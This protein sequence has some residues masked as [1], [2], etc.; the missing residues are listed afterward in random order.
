MANRS[1]QAKEMKRKRQRK[2]LPA[3]YYADYISVGRPPDRE[4][5]REHKER[6]RSLA[7]D[8]EMMKHLDSIT[9]FKGVPPGRVEAREAAQTAISIARM[10]VVDK[11]REEIPQL[12]FFNLPD[13]NDHIH[14]A[15][16]FFNSEKTCFVIMYQH[17]QKGYVKRSI[18]Y[19]SKERLLEKWKC[20]QIT[21]VDY[22]PSPK[23]S[24]E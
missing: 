2:L 15:S 19:A 18:T 23:Q 13:A 22:S 7:F 12:L 11:I 21:W 5:M 10:T 14:R 24:S 9:R 8:P 17:F 16:V 20:D 1:M 6:N 4:V 3:H